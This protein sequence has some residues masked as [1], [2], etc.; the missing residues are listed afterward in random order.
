[1]IQKEQQQIQLKNQ[2]NYYLFGPV[3]IIDTPGFD[4]FGELGEKRVAQTK[5]ILR[6]C[7]VAVLVTT[8]EREFEEKE[9]ELIEIFKER[10]IPYLIV[11][12]KSDLL[13]RVPNNSGNIV[14][15]SSLTGFGIE[16]VKNTI[17]SLV[18]DDE[19]EIHLVSDFIDSGDVVVLVTPIDGSAPKGRLILPQQLAIRDILDKNGI[20]VVTQLPELEETLKKVTPKLV[21]TD[22][23]VFNKVKE[24]VPE[25]IYLTSFSI[26]MAR[27]KGFLDTAI[28]G[29]R[30]LD[31]LKDSSKVLIA[32]GCT[33]HRQ[34]EDI[35]TVKLPK[36]IKDYTK[37]NIEFEWTSG[38]GFPDDLTKFDLVI[39]CGGC[40][41]SENEVKYR[42]ETAVKQGVPF[43]NYGTT[44]AYIQGILDR[45]LKILEK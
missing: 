8:A 34:C 3:T 42:M 10:E 5:K 35:G 21:V 43:T 40:M 11:K 28:K 6:S 13:K 1:M 38:T 45:S 7:D 33:H 39:H 23:Q 15:S 14:Y 9:N 22:S 37:K 18:K 17:G 16:E 41:L 19:N 20:A 2:W 25:E 26:L 4:D 27:F 12:N 32:E 29:V 24:I 44:I 36:W 30:V 31:K